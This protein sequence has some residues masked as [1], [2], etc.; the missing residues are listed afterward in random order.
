MLQAAVDSGLRGSEII[1]A[2]DWETARELPR[3]RIV[4]V[5][6]CDQSTM[7]DEPH[8][9]LFQPPK[10]FF[11]SLYVV[12]NSVDQNTATSATLINAAG[13]Y[14][15]TDAGMRDLVARL[16]SDR[17]DSNA[18]L[19]SVI[20]LQRL[21]PATNRYRKFFED[22]PIGFIELETTACFKL[23]SELRNQGV[24]RLGTYLD[25]HPECF[26]RLCNRILVRNANTEAMRTLGLDVN[27]QVSGS[28]GRLFCRRS[29]G[30]MR[31][32]ILALWNGAEGTRR[33]A[34]HVGLD[35]VRRQVS[36]Q[37]HNQVPA[38]GGR[39]FSSL[40]LVD[41]SEHHDLRRE[42]ER[43]KVRFRS[44][45][46]ASF[47][48][49]FFSRKGE[50]ID[51][52]Q[53]AERL[54]GYSQEEAVGRMGTEWIAESDR[55]LVMKKMMSGDEEPYQVTALRK[56]G[57]TFPCEIQARMIQFPGEEPV[58]IT[59]L[60]D[61][62]KRAKAEVFNE[63]FSQVLNNS[64][65][66]VLIMDLAS[67]E[68][69]GANRSAR[70]S[71]GLDEADCANQSFHTMFRATG[72]QSLTDVVASFTCQDQPEYEM[73]TGELKRKDGSV[74][75]VEAH[76]QSVQSNSPALTLV[77]ID[78][79]ERLEAQREKQLMDQRLQQA[80]K[81][82][83]LGVLAGGVAHDF[84]NI[85]MTILGNADLA[86][87]HLPDDARAQFN[88]QEIIRASKRAADL[89]KQMLA[90]SGKGA[91]VIQP[92]NLSAIVRDMSHLLEVTISK[93]ALLRLNLD[94]HLPTVLADATQ[95]RQVV[96]NLI[97]NA[98]EAHGEQ[99][100]FIDICTGAV[101]LN[102]KD[103]NSFSHQIPT[104]WLEDIQPGKFVY[105]GVKD[106]GCGMSAQTMERIF[107]PFFSTKFTGRG[108]GM[109]AVL[110]IVR[111][112]HGLIRVESKPDEGSSFQVFLPESLEK[113]ET[114][115][116]RSDQPGAAPMQS[117]RIL[118]IDD[119]R[120]V[121]IIAEEILTH[122]GHEV[123]AVDG[124]HAALE[125]LRDS[126]SGFDL[127]L[128]DLT[129]PNMD[130]LQTFKELHQL[131]PD[132]KVVLCSGY[133]KQEATRNFPSGGLHGFLQ[134]PYGVRKIR[135][136]LQQYFS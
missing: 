125:Q 124:G 7:P 117:K 29:I 106:S 52:N 60:R 3:A 86:S 76:V 101:E 74:S 136:A 108:L 56:D 75:S 119:E 97:T 25:A 63:F 70:E 9:A 123:I 67:L 22:S 6:I 41:V 112:H 49:I 91:F 85:L 95:L 78:I 61:I 92:V 31:D 28:V 18:S 93:N 30:V 131:A 103:I 54:F 115:F 32:E 96:M 83:S 134:K 43:S 111:G 126:D 84:N 64:P 20:E 8:A 129:M 89:A 58:R 68:V 11:Q 33:E 107:D 48:A 88:L 132:L 77:M 27:A 16:H 71:L 102:Q 55:E 5:V 47:E 94:D 13:N 53:T 14:E 1:H 69:I 120:D 23:M 135:D 12:S 130:G 133:S 50:C 72:E 35:G 62:S 59:A 114:R 118:V 66:E 127:V 37:F 82:E 65:N 40:A 113:P 45:A 116:T 26:V 99:S 90:Y 39:I 44:L 10:Q 128:L 110:G 98:S 46:Q 122:L 36:F 19:G 2:E 80:Q 87:Y 100:G 79:T 24:D 15:K 4:D 105:L 38:T 17:R 34:E 57:S 42:L 51:Q 73:I 21:Q 104:A 109:S 81:M 121:R